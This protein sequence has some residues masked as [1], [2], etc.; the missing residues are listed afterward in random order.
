[1]TSGGN[2][3]NDFHENQL[4]K[5]QLGGKNITILHTFA[6]PFHYKAMMVAVKY[7]VNPFTAD[8]LR[9]HTLP[10]W[11][12]PPFL[13]VDIRALWGSWLS[14]RAPELHQ[15][16]DKPSEQQLQQQF[17]PAGVEGVNMT[18]LTVINE[19]TLTSAG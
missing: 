16:I 14:G 5:F 9:L 15:Y 7:N 19:Q 4:T 12:N 13:I 6:A 11:S 18:L 8:P 2:N 1:M 3:F 10:Y 17:G